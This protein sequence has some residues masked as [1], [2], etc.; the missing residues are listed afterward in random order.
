MRVGFLDIFHD[1]VGHDDNPPGRGSGRFPWGSGLNPFQHHH[2]F[3]SEYNKLLKQDPPLTKAEI[4]QTLLG[5]RRYD[6]DGKPVYATTTDLR[7]AV[8]ISTSE[9][10]KAKRAR[11]LELYDKLHGNVSAVGR[12]MGINESSVRSLLDDAIAER[13]DR[14]TNTADFLKKKIAESEYGMIDISKGVEL[15]MNCTDYTKKVAVSMLEQEGYVKSWVKIPTGKDKFTTEMVLAAPPKD[16]ETS[17]DVYRKIQEHRFEVGSIQEFTPDGGKTWWIPEFPESLDSSRVFIRYAED[18]G[19]E[20]DGVIELRR[21]VEDISLGGTQYAQV[22]IAVDGTNYMKGMAMYGDDIPDGYDVVYNTNKHKGTPMIDHNATYDAAED[23]WSGSEV[24]KRMKINAET[25]EV[26]Q[27]NPFGALIKSPKDKDGVITAGGQRHYI[28]KDGNSKLSPINK[29]QDEGDWDSWSRTLSAQFLSKQPV[30]II[31]EQLDLSLKDKDKELDEIRSLTNPVLKKKMLEDY[32]AKCDAN[33]ADLSAKGFKNQAFQVLLPLSNIS[34]KEVYAPNYDDGDILALVRYPHG[35]IFEIPVL[36]VNNRNESGKKCMQNAKDAIGINHLVAEQLSG[37]DFDGDTALVIPL[38]SNRLDISHMDYLSDLVGFDPKEGYK[39]PDSAPKM[40][41]R[42]KQ[43]EM[44]RATNLITDMTVGGANWDQITRAV[45]HSMVVIDAQKHHLDYQQSYKDFGIEDLKRTYQGTTKTGQ[46]KGASTI[47]SKAGAGTYINKR[48]EVT[49][50]KKMTPE[51][52]ERYNQ[53]KRVYRDTGET[54]LTMIKKTSK[55][56]SEEL[57]RYNQG[58]KIFRDTGKPKQIEIESMY[59]VDDAF[60]LVRDKNNPKEVLYAKYANGLKSRADTAR[61]ESRAIKTTPVSQE[62]KKTYAAEVE[63]LNTKLRNVEMNAP[64]E[65]KARA[66]ANT[67]MRD[68]L[69]SNPGMDVE[70]R[71]REEALCLTRARAAVGAKKDPIVIT[72][73]EWEAIQSNA[74][75]S[76]KLA[77]IF[78]NTNQDKLKQRATPRESSK[79]SEADIARIKQLKES[80]NLSTK[81]IAER[82][83]VS[84]S[85]IVRLS[86]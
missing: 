67:L 71:S 78:A 83:G 24:L 59:T 80:G 64:I 43:N 14:Y 62:A 49:D 55:M 77:K 36:T 1:G 50:T 74:I 40:K 84:A 18:G 79:L 52:L 75:S 4:A 8:A 46:V 2:D 85:T 47:L 63:S 21:G 65:R 86:T 15:Y 5:V 51:E 13:R 32:A 16:G 26:D 73:R 27:E 58:K 11:A 70:H 53:G 23:K 29:L 41:N 61:K 17:K 33:A 56:T 72:D 10:G 48:K 31:G 39:L 68:R 44:G 6:K 37:A 34:P 81:Q 19:K 35:G 25:G 66:L 20:K 22:R 38:K 57:E 7:A 9:E 76:T 3:L 42:T 30:K 12:E 28:D 69:A 60:D 45:K 54:K 82:F